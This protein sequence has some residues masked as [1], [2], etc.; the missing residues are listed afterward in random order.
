MRGLLLWSQIEQYQAEI[1]R[2]RESEAEIKALS[3]NYAA[4]LKEK[5]VIFVASYFLFVQFTFLFLLSIP[6]PEWIFPILKKSSPMTCPSPFLALNFSPGWRE[7]TLSLNVDLGHTKVMYC[8]PL[9]QPCSLFHCPFARMFKVA[10]VVQPSSTF[11]S[12]IWLF[13]I[14]WL[15]LSCI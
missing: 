7:I 15:I 11:Y 5:E 10:N 9:W 3:V 12:G 2:L 14:G 8:D 4:L 13:F 6:S 1:K